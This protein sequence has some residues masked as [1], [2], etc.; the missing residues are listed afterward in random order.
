LKGM[1]LLKKWATRKARK[2]KTAM[3]KWMRKNEASFNEAK[4]KKDDRKALRNQKRAKKRKQ[5]RS[6][7]D[8]PLMQ[9][10]H[11]STTK[12]TTTPPVVHDSEDYAPLMQRKH[13]STTKPK[14]TPPTLEQRNNGLSA[15]EPPMVR[16]APLDQ[17]TD[18]EED[19]TGPAEELNSETHRTEPYL[20]NSILCPK[21]S[22]DQAA[23]PKLKTQVPGQLQRTSKIVATPIHPA[24][25]KSVGPQQKS[26]RVSESAAQGATT[27]SVRGDNAT[28]RRSSVP[29]VTA[30]LPASFSEVTTLSVPSRL[31]PS[32]APASNKNGTAYKTTNPIR[33][34]NG[35]KD[36]PKNQW[37]TDGVLYNKLKFRGIADKR[38]RAEGTPDL[39][40]LESVGTAPSNLSKP[41]ADGLADN[42]YGRREAGTRRM[43]ADNADEY[44]RR[45]PMDET[46]ALK[47]WEVNKVPLVCYD[48]RLSNNCRFSAQNCKFMH[49]NCD[50][51]GRSLKIGPMDGIIP[52]KYRATPVTCL[53]W[54]QNKYG[55]MKSADD[56]DFAHKNTGWIPDST[57]NAQLVRVDPN[58]LPVS[59]RIDNRLPMTRNARQAEK[60]NTPDL[61]C[62][63][64]AN[65]VC[66]KPEKVCNFKHY[67]TGVV[68]NPPPGVEICWYFLNG[69]C[70]YTAS[71]CKNVHPKEGANIT[72]INT[73]SNG[74]YF[75]I[76]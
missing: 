39:Y 27:A 24:I 6:E 26:R 42:P 20:G 18:D 2:G 32:I 44:V 7:N 31:S 10:K 41:R 17:S 29:T 55:C 23:Q 54:L 9:R 56:C 71:E 13:V 66:K 73:D 76:V 45:E 16:R 57:K 8:V 34:T 21:N 30:P 46:T 67:Q 4:K 52:P 38:S 28:E 53:Y 63:D 72:Q 51:N 60:N 3:T 35:P 64:W 37:N 33:I 15:K 22:H 70:R 58:A 40:A 19:S 74:E 59:E 12:P 5:L 25:S 75:V 11:F 61:T 36:A 68:A 47:K 65:G 14:A 62:W 48:Y 43:E 49:R 69:W 50:E 1:D